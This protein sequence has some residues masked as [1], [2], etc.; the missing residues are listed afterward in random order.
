MK[1]NVA[2]IERPAGR[3][4]LSRPFTLIELLVV[5]AIIAILAAMLLPALQQAR[6]RGKTAKCISNLKN[7]ALGVQGYCDVSNDIMP[8]PFWYCVNINGQSVPDGTDGAKSYWQDVFVAMKLVD[9][10]MPKSWLKVTGLYQC[11][12]E[13]EERTAGTYGYYNTWKGS[14]YGMNRY[15][16]LAYSSVASKLENYRPRKITKAV[17]PSV[18]FSVG[19]KWVSPLSPSTACQAEIRGRWY[20]MATRHSGKWNYATLDGG[21]KAGGVNILMGKASDYTDYLAAPSKW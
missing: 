19:D 2:L 11:P 9:T 10:P 5:I 21:V 6:E 20:Q 17:R 4:A 1:N 3:T 14:H 13:V 18:T 12:T 7:L 8:K 15:L 16:S